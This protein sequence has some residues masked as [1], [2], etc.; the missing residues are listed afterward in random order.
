MPR[1]GRPKS[2]NPKTA[3]IKT[4]VEPEVKKAFLD[5]CE[6]KGLNQSDLI[7]SWVLEFLEN[8]KK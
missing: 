8:K 3:Y 5:K 4:R 7:R 2:D 6:S 1:T